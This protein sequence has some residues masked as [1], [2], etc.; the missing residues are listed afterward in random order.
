MTLAIAVVNT[1]HNGFSDRLATNQL[2]TLCYAVIYRHEIHIPSN[3]EMLKSHVSFR[4][5][6]S[7]YRSTASTS[8]Y[9]SHQ[10]QPNIEGLVPQV[11]ALRVDKQLHGVQG[12]KWS[13]VS[14]VRGYSNGDVLFGGVRHN[15]HDM[16]E[17]TRRELREVQI[18]YPA[19]QAVH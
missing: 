12:A 11:G 3:A 14:A 8:L 19:L 9:P 10:L 2:C 7:P 16:A 4:S 15:L 1:R 5:S 6:P 13:H 17:D 18:V